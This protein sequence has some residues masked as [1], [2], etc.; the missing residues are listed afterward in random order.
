V[1]ARGRAVY[2]KHSWDTEERRFI[3]LIG[4]LTGAPAG[5]AAKI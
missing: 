5:A 3:E 1:L 4:G 2:D